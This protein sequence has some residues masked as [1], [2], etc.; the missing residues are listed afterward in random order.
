[1]KG[2]AIMLVSKSLLKHLLHHLL[3]SH[4]SKTY[5]III[6]W[7]SRLFN[8]IFYMTKLIT[9]PNLT[10][11]DLCGK[12]WKI[13]YSQSRSKFLI[14]VDSTTHATHYIVYSPNLQNLFSYL[15]VGCPTSFEMIWLT[16]CILLY[17][18]FLSISKR[19]DFLYDSSS[20]EY[21]N[22]L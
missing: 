3:G 9:K 4:I 2:T 12:Q 22:I 20:K 7:T 19:D 6:Y 1:M 21:I 11:V 14:S 5:Y 15:Q 10:R 13:I 16:I 18:I 17:N 8:N